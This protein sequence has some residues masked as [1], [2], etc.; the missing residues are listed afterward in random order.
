MVR[1]AEAMEQM[2]GF[3]R[4]FIHY[5]GPDDNKNVPRI[6]L[7][8]FKTRDEYLKLGIGPPVEWSGGHFTGNAVE[9]YI[10]QGGFEECITTLFHEAAHQ[11]VGLATTASGWLNEGLASFFE[12]SAC[13]RT[14]RCR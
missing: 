13:W 9:T 12:G 2:N 11:F 8:I 3:Y 14:A 5:G 6:E 10:G 7:H 4:E 1:A